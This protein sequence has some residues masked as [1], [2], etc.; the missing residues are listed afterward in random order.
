MSSRQ[1]EADDLLE[2]DVALLMEILVGVTHNW[3][4]LSIS[5]GM[6]T[7]V[8]EDCRGGGSNTDRK[9]D[10]KMLNLQI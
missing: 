5:L 2:E 1:R 9:V 4:E 6:P 8:L 7:A 10:T 3:N